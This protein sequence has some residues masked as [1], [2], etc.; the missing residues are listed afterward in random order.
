MVLGP[1]SEVTRF[2]RD[3]RPR[4]LEAPKLRRIVGTVIREP[5]P[6]DIFALDMMIG[7]GQELFAERMKSLG[8]DTSQK[9]YVFQ[10]RAAW[11]GDGRGHFR[12]LSRRYPSLYFVLAY[13][14][15]N[16]GEYGSYLIR[17]GRSQWYRVSD[18]TTDSVMTKHGWDEN[19]DDDDNE[20][21]WLEA[22]WELTAQAES[23]WL[24]VVY[25]RLGLRVRRNDTNA[26][27]T[28]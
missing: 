9:E 13:H 25:K 14:A 20:L 17:D 3:A 24:N 28:S 18:N 22:S 19:N 16:I 15:N 5:R 7:E 1:R 12:K 11:H 23:R 21:A 26:T 2:A 27:V 4:V 6:N 10:V 8:H